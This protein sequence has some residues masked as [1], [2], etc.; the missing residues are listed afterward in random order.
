MK[1]SRYAGLLMLLCSAMAFAQAA[2]PSS[3]VAW[4]LPGDSVA[5]SAAAG[6]NAYVDALP[7]SLLSGVTCVAS[8]APAPVPGATCTANW[9]AMTNGT[10]NLTLT[11]VI[12]TAESPKGTPIVASFTV[13]VTPTGI[14]IVP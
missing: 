6:Y 7:A 10:H 8:V 13:T 4:D 11:Q 5:I 1:T 9:P 2:S 3:H 12:G 14:R